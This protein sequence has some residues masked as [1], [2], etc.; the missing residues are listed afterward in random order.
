MKNLPFASLRAFEAAARHESFVKAAAELHL[1]AAGI[2]Q[3][4][5]T[6][7]NWL[8]IPLFVRHTRGVAL[9]AAGREFGAAVT[10]GLTHIETAAGKLKFE[11][12]SRPISVACIASMATRWLIPQLPRF[13]ATHPN[14]RINIVYALDAKTPE[15]AGA[16]LLIR[17]GVRPDANAI[18]LLDAETRPTC[19]AEFL[20]RHG[21]FES[22]RDLLKYELLH[23]E[24]F[25]AWGR[26]FH[27]VGINLAP[28]TG[29]VFADFSLMIGPVIGGQGIGL[30]PTSL[31]AT[32]IA[33]GSLVT[34]FDTPSDTEKAYWLIQAKGLPL[35]AETLRDWLVAA[36]RKHAGE[37]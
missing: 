5:R 28:K 36:S 27:A 35:E 32:E 22:P 37:S 12:P 10:N 9:T 3:H 34:M 31:I 13:K 21:P 25:D 6:L 15:A 29:P 8:D 11:A 26:W 7:E 17:H 24:T 2:S 20:A 33:E 4:V 19:S 1:T 30:C 18:E 23:D 16:D 14:I